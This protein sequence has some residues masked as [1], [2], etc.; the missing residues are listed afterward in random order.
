MEQ[1]QRK[2]ISSIWDRKHRELL[3]RGNVGGELWWL[4]VKERAEPQGAK[5][6]QCHIEAFE[7]DPQGS[8]KPWES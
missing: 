6:L 2:S 5:G 7:L 4:N 1:T 3:G 8:R